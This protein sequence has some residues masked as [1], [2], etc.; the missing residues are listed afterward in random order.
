M[1]ITQLLGGAQDAITVTRVFGEAYERD[2]TTVIPV[3][4]VSGGGGGGQGGAAE[5]GEGG[6]LGYGLKAEPAG[7]YVIKDGTVRWEPAVDVNRMVLGFQVLAL[8]V[9][10]LLRTIVK[11]G[12]KAVGKA[13]RR[14]R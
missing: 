12:S 2:G 1:D 8:A 6:G 3:A 11:R 14:Q 5:Q 4:R 13:G 7:A 9:V 10:L